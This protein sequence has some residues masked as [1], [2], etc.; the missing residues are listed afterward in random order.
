MRGEGGREKVSSCADAE[1][2]VISLHASALILP[3]RPFMAREGGV[4]GK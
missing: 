4:P 2:K 3:P 1:Q